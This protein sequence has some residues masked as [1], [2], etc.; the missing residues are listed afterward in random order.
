MKNSKIF[1]R[2]KLKLKEWKTFYFFKKLSF[3][4]ILKDIWKTQPLSKFIPHYLPQKSTNPLHQFSKP[5]FTEPNVES[6]HLFLQKFRDE[7]SRDEKSCDEKSRDEMSHVKK[8][9]WKWDEDGMKICDE[10]VRYEMS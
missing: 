5:S 2:E 1:S 8:V 7:K 9:G 4:K 6:L 10:S 3:L